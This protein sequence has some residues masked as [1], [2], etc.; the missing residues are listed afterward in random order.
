[1]RA[2]GDRPD[3]HRLRAPIVLLW[4][5]GLR[6]SEARALNERDLDRFRGAGARSA[7][8]RRQPARGW[9]GPL[10]MGAAPTRGSRFAATSR[11]ERQPDSRPRSRPAF[12]VAR[13]SSRRRRQSRNARQARTPAAPRRRTSSR[14]PLRRPSA[15]IPGGSPIASGC[16]SGDESGTLRS[17]CRCFLGSDSQSVES[18]RPKKPSRVSGSAPRPVSPPPGDAR[19]HSTISG[20]RATRSAASCQLVAHDQHAAVQGGDLA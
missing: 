11:P 10:S 15:R 2:V 17:G 3:A 8:K 4:R 13:A 1:M 14:R 12:V 9:D 6:I 16:A 5:A 19:R 7:R 20:R 18:N